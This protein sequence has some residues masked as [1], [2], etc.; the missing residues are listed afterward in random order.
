MIDFS[1]VC[2]D[3]CKLRLLLYLCNYLI[4]FKLSQNSPFGRANKDIVLVLVIVMGSLQSLQ[5]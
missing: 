1:L 2:N 4:I 5:S 3:A